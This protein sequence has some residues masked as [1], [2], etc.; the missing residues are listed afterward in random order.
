MNKEEAEVIVQMYS[1]SSI[2]SVVL[3]KHWFLMMSFSLFI[4]N[5]TQIDNCAD[6]SKVS[7]QARAV[8]FTRRKTRF[9]K[10]TSS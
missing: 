8:A 2:E 6:L 10:A 4:H 5:N 3:E 1:P 9:G 7:Y